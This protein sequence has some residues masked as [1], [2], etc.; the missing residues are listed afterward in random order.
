MPANVYRT[1]IGPFTVY[2]DDRLYAKYSQMSS[3][4]LSERSR[5]TGKWQETEL[6]Q[7]YKEVAGEMMINQFLLLK[8]A[9]A[10]IDTSTYNEFAKY[11]TNLRFITVSDAPE[12]PDVAHKLYTLMNDT[13]DGE[14]RRIQ[15]NYYTR[16]TQANLE[17]S[18]LGQI[19]NGDYKTLPALGKWPYGLASAGTNSGVLVDFFFVAMLVAKEDLSEI[20]AAT[21]T[22]PQLSQVTVSQSIR[23]DAG[24]LSGTLENTVRDFLTAV[25]GYSTEPLAPGGTSGPGGGD[26]TFD[27]SSTPIDYPG[28]PSIGAFAT[29]FVNIYVPSAADLRALSAYMW[30]GAF[31]IDNF[32]KIV[33][34]PMDAIMGLSILP[35]SASQIGVQ[36]SVLAVGNISTG[37]SMPHAT[38]QYVSVDCGTVE[39]LPKWGAYLDFAPYSKLQ[40]YLPYIG[41]VDISL[42]DVM[43]G[44]IGVRYSIDIL[45]GTCIAFVKCKDH[46]I[47]EFGG[48]CSCQCPVTE[49]Q[50]KNGL[51]GVLDLISGVG[52]LVSAG[53]SA[54]PSSKGNSSSAQMAANIGGAVVG[55]VD[56]IEGM[57][58]TVISMV[59]PNI[60]R[61]GA[62]GGSAGLMSYQMPYLVLTIPHMCVPGEQNTYMGYPSFITMEMSELTGYT[63]INVTHLNNM[64]CTDTE[65]AE[66]LT[67]LNTGVIF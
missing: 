34:D 12:Y 54:V 11:A 51:F 44:S 64:S 36:S 5:V 31:D 20:L 48:S 58:G 29:G 50:Y 17:S 33:A 42:D 7:T 66:I 23:F 22:T 8:N 38:S 10:Q 6:G 46:V 32:R 60:G 49:G 39:V 30:A 61:S 35:V 2:A 59:K 1:V 14:V 27:F 4:A 65:I 57:A 62:V 16:G 18:C 40:L 52:Q 26:G 3:G 43:N 56:A 63:E 67:L 37:L 41:F 25:D 28:L 15:L 24:R 19:G 21:I 45:S 53:S 13:E 9:S 55:A 47:Y